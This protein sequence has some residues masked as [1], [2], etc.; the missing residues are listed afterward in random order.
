VETV[1]RAVE[2]DAGMAIVPKGTVTQEVEKGT[3]VAIEFE[4]ADFSRP[5]AAI[6]KKNKV[7]SPAM[8]EFLHTLKAELGEEGKRV[9][10]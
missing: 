6:F 3:L 1:K 10:Q 7:L 2:I 8:R 9:K 5:L 4:D